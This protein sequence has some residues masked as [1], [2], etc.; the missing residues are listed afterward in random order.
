MAIGAQKPLGTD[1]IQF[2]L[3]KMVKV[4]DPFP[5]TLTSNEY[6]RQREYFNRPSCDTRLQQHLGTRVFS[7]LVPWW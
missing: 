7:A 6:S 4:F 5:E 2:H 1:P 3:D